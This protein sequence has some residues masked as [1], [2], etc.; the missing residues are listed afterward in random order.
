MRFGYGKMTEASYA[1]LR[2]K[3]AAAARAWLRSAPITTAATMNPPPT[4]ALQVA[5]TARG[6]RSS[7]CPHR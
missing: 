1:L 3:D 2:I 5:F 6:L 7:A 4:T